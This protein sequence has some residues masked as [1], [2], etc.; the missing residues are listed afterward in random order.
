MVHQKQRDGKLDWAN[1]HTD[2]AASQGLT[3]L[4]RVDVIKEAQEG[5]GA[6]NVAEVKWAAMKLKK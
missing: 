4:T 1:T 3:Q 2:L 5:F 6:R